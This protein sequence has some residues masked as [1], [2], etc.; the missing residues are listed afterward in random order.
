M[1]TLLQQIKGNDFL[2][3]QFTDISGRLRHV[4]VPTKAVE[5]SDFDNGFPK[6]DGSSVRGF[7]DISESD[8]VLR[9]C[10]N[11]YGEIPWAQHKTCR[12]ICDILGLDVDPRKV[13]RTAEAVLTQRGIWS[14]WGPELEFFV[15]D[16]NMKSVE[17]IRPKEGYFPTSPVD[18][19]DDY[20]SSFVQ[21]LK[22]SFKI[23]TNA[24]HHEVASQGQCE[25][26]MKC[27]GLVEMADNAVTYKYVAK[28]VAFQRGLLASFMPKP[29]FGDSGS[30]MH[31]HSSFWT[32]GASAGGE[33]NLFYDGDE[34]YA[35]LS[36]L[37]RYYIGGI[38]DHA[39]ALSAIVAPTTN[40]YRRLVP[41]YEAPT[42]ITWS[43]AN[44]SAIVRIPD[45]QR[46]DQ[47]N[48]RIEFRAPD[49]SCNPYLAFAAILAAGLDGIAES[50]E[51]GDPVRGSAYDMPEWERKKFGI[52]EL[53]SNLSEAWEALRSD[54]LFLK[55]FFPQRLLNA[56]EEFAMEDHRTV[57]ARPHP[58]EFELYRDI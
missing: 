36:Q 43:R 34:W 12:L 17:T 57:S 23:E 5:Q 26:D 32:G 13:A 52:E 28:N 44:R 55:D 15:L 33:R 49:P 56:M 27:K 47:R 18:M 37:A 9:P 10:Q 25:I 21:V 35:E 40:S 20:R 31:V 41:G 24:H 48:K 4:T 6:L 22:G 7:A 2:D 19:L 54:E 3:L 1:V 38:L 42:Y 8:L 39:R 53:P 46:G 45:Y 58:Y 11:T 30:G 14:L 50:I 16:E 51:P 29:F